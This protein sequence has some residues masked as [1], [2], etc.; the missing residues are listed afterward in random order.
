[1]VRI[2]TNNSNESLEL[3]T[4]IV[5][6]VFIIEIVCIFKILPFLLLLLEINITQLL[7]S[8]DGSV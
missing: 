6:M 5:L 8:Y 4:I 3:S 1:M 2:E 7:A